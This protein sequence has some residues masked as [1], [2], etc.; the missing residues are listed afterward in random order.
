[1]LR[2]LDYTNK[3][4]EKFR[5]NVIQTIF[6]LFFC[7]KIAGNRSRYFSI[8]YRSPLEI[9]LF[10]DHTICYKGVNGVV[11]DDYRLSQRDIIKLQH[12]HRKAKTKFEADRLKSIYL[13]GAGWNP[14]TVAHIL[15]RDERTMVLLT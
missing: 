13:L 15:D 1:M 3:K 2:H 5:P 10:R 8:V 7:G 12:H 9:G 14:H 6:R 4:A 11:M